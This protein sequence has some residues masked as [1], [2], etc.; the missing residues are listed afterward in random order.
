[1]LRGVFKGGIFARQ[2]C[3]QFHGPVALPNMPWRGA[4]QKLIPTGVVDFSIYIP[5][6]WNIDLIPGV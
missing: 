6:V 2:F 4:G 1:M 3:S 5:S